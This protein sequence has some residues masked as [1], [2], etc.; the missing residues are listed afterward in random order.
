MTKG[1]F[2]LSG[3]VTLVTGGN[4]GLGLGFARGIARQGGD[5]EIWGRS[6]QK[7]AAAKEELEAFGV[8]VVTR[9]V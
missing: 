8:R 1:L 3:K 7:N 4:G 6:T 2:D 9:Q 5:L